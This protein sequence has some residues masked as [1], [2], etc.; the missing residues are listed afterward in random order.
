M[1]IAMD[2]YKSANRRK[3]VV[4]FLLLIGIL[5]ISVFALYGE[6]S[7]G[8]ENKLIKD[9]SLGMLTLVGIL[10][11]LTIAFQVPRELRDKTAMTLFAK[12]LGREAYMLGKCLGIGFLVLRNMAVIAIG[13]LFIM[14]L[15]G[16]ASGEF[17]M[18]YLQSFILSFVASIDVI[19]LTLILCVFLS[20]GLVVIF[21][22]G[23]F[24]LGNAIYMLSYSESGLSSIAGYLK[25]VIPNFF[26]FDIKTEVSS[27][28]ATSAPYMFVTAGYGLVYAVM[29]VSLALI[30]FSKKDL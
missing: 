15:K 30:L 29:A 20:E 4:Y 1:V 12:P 16:V 22:L 7:L 21:S 11:G 14:N 5:Q 2:A 17:I 18:A 26:L 19:A 8:I 3:G 9:V 28:L 25:Y 10:S 24:L 6:I 23:F 27:N 13:A